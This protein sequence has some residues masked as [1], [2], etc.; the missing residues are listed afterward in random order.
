MS[1]QKSTN[2]YMVV[3]PAKCKCSVNEIRHIPQVSQ[4]GCDWYN[5]VQKVG[6][7]GTLFP[8]GGGILA[9][10]FKK[11]MNLKRFFTF[12]FENCM[13]FNYFVKKGVSSHPTYPSTF[14]RLWWDA[15]S[16]CYP[17]HFLAPNLL[18]MGYWGIRGTH[19]H[20]NLK[21]TCEPPA[22]IHLEC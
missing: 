6:A 7:I 20:L 5:F 2:V 21:C 19:A 14:G 18:K 11:C 8:E 10:L 15:L 1:T 16:T 13:I 12:F 22:A 4:R 3:P 17:E 9:K